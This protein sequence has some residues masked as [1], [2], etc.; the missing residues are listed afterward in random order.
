SVFVVL[1]TVAM[2]LFLGQTGVRGAFDVGVGH[3]LTGTIWKPEAGVFGGLALIVGTFTSAIGA[4]VLGATPAV[5]AALWVTEFAPDSVRRSYRRVMEIAA[6]IPSV[7]YGWLAL[8]YLVPVVDG[9]AHAL[10]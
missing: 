9:F 2:L 6:A 1:T 3:L 4:I 5:L 10:R 7:V 8:V